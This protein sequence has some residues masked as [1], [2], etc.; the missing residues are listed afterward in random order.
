[1]KACQCDRC[2]AFYSNLNIIGK[3]IFITDSYTSPIKT[4]KFKDLCDDCQKEL[5]TWWKLKK[6]EESEEK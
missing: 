5:E 3:E 2:G 4:R 6:T 1:M